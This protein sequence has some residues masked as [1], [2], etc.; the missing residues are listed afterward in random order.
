MKT[1]SHLSK[2]RIAAFE[3]CPKRL[4]LMTYR[5]DLA[6]PPGPPEA[7]LAVG[8]AVGAQACD[9]CAGGVMVEAEPDLS[10]ALATTRDLL[11]R[12]HD[13]PIFEATFEHNDV[14]VR[15][16]I[17]EPRDG[18]WHLVEVKSSTKAKPEHDRDLATQLW[19]AQGAGLPVTGASIRHLDRS[20]VLK[21]SGDYA[22]LF[23]DTPRIDALAALVAERPAVVAAARAMLAG[24][25]PE[26][27]V[28]EHCTTPAPCLFIDYCNRDLP[29]GPEWPVT[30]LPNGGG[31]AF[32]N[33]GII[34]LLEV[35][36]SSLRNAKHARIHRATVTGRVDHDPVGAAAA[37]AGWTYPRIW[38]DFETISDAIPIWPGCSPY[39]QVPFQFVAEIE[40]ADGA[41]ERRDFLS[42]DGADPRH[43]C[44]E[45]LALL[46]GEGAVIAWNAGFERG[47]IE[48]LARAFPDLAETLASLAAR[49]VDLLPV[50]REHWYHRDQR[51]S[52]SIKAVLPTIAPELD[53]AGLE[54]KDGGNAVE[55]YRE[56]VAPDC[57][58]PRRMVL[59]G[60]LRDY[61]GRD[62]EAMRVVAKALV[63]PG[64]GAV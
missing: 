11:A 46:P 8:R 1:S 38:L 9:H 58:E 5:R 60:A 63:T 33:D 32:L 23:A 16:D 7:R 24:Y 10:A 15:I 6:A 52:W 22:G 18:G 13:A 45:A 54:V 48:Q 21:R 35:D 40:T 20:F 62:V 59:A 64:A 2:S 30:I 49:V 56:A 14:L 12:G 25:E 42:L 50:A 17:L 41:I 43:A 36:A 19:V 47:V 3:R 51:G 55:A 27:P 28:G 34:D 53:Y 4:W 29:A 26:H 44:A 57:T 37:M 39:D 31:K 61:C